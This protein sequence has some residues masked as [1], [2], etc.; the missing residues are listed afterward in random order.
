MTDGLMD[1]RKPIANR[2][3]WKGF[4]NRISYFFFDK[5]GIKIGIG[6]H[7]ELYF[8]TLALGGETGELQNV[9]KKMWRDGHSPE[10]REKAIK[11]IADCDIYLQHIADW[12][13]IERDVNAAAK[14][15]EC[16]DR[17]PDIPR[18][19]YYI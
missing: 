14:I 19:E 3:T 10:L 6:N 15:N 9:V 1:D 16:L 8:L 4:A 17:W 12:F 18:E 5:M 2:F 13:G 11:E 7:S